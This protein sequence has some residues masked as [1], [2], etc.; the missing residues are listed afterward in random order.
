MTEATYWKATVVD[1]SIKSFN[2]LEDIV[3]NTKYIIYGDRKRSEILTVD[4]MLQL[5]V[6]RKENY[7]KKL[8]EGSYWQIIRLQDFNIEEF[9]ENHEKIIYKGE[10]PISC[11]RRGSQIRGK[12]KREENKRYLEERRT[13]QSDDDNINNNK[14]LQ[15][16]KE[17]NKEITTTTIPYLDNMS[18]IREYNELDFLNTPLIQQL[19]KKQLIKEMKEDRKKYEEEYKKTLSTS[20]ESDE[21]MEKYIKKDRKELINNNKDNNI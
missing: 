2:D 1:P 9:E 21:T 3:K 4:I 16:E 13:W 6:R 19:Y 10:E 18:E 7:M 20:E 14:A 15:K 5:K 11:Y 8:V 17:N 12:K